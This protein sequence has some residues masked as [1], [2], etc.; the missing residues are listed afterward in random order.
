MKRPA[1]LTGWG[2]LFLVVGLL[3]QL[4]AYLLAP[5]TPLALLSGMLG[6]CSVVLCSQGNIW[7]F[8]FGFGQILTYAWLCWQERFYA[9]IAMNT[10]YFVSQ[11][12]G[13]WTWSQR[14]TADSEQSAG[15]I[16]TRRL[17]PAIFVSITL[18]S[19]AL[20]VLTGWLL[21]RYTDDSQPWLDAF[22][23]VPAIAAQILLVLA[24]R[25]QWFY[26]LAI[27]I[28][29]LALWMRADNWSMVMQYAFW[30]INC[31]YGL[32]SWNRHI[33]APDSTPQDHS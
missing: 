22:T 15:S 32:L 20:S 27:D 23:T 14:R 29:Y 3:V 31:I 30:C 18:I 33:A 11:F 10:F 7:T 26:W 5:T 17:S 24:Y 13:L 4:I 9:G 28:A 12:V 2:G 16:A 21:C 1:W 6:I 8:L 19:I 25:E